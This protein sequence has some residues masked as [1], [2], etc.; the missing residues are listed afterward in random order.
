VN[1]YRT[2]LITFTI[3]AV[4]T[5]FYSVL[6]NAAEPECATVKTTW[7]ILDCEG[8]RLK[9]ATQALTKLIKQL[10]LNLRAPQRKALEKANAAWA[11]YRQAHCTA[12]S[13]LY[14]GGT[15]ENVELANCMSD[16]TIARVEELRFRYKH[17]LE[18]GSKV[19]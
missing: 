7:E 5:I 11:S 9:K 2:S 12:V 17:V 13:L 15:L 4:C 8:W 3:L 1:S 18:L 10:D 14:E 16:I 6:M 19:K